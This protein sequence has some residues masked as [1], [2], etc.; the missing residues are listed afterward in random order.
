M[1]KRSLR[2]SSLWLD[3]STGTWPKVRTCSSSNACGCSGTKPYRCFLV[4]HVVWYLISPWDLLLAIPGHFSRNAIPL[5]APIKGC[6]M[7][8]LLWDRRLVAQ[9]KSA[10]VDDQAYQLTIGWKSVNISNSPRTEKDIWKAKCSPQARL[11]LSSLIRRDS[12]E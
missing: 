10:S 11:S 12:G 5:A 1:R 4:P 8:C 2:A 3:A 9:S 6:V 7:V